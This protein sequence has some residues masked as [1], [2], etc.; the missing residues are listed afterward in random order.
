M[1]VH[2]ISTLIFKFVFLFFATKQS[3]PTPHLQYCI[4]N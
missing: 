3:D 2:D 1:Y 4:I